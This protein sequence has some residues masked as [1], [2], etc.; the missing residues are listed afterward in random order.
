MLVSPSRP[1]PCRDR[2]ARAV[3]AESS[4]SD[5]RFFPAC[6]WGKGSPS[7]PYL[8]V[9]GLLQCRTVL[10]PVPKCGSRKAGGRLR[11]CSWP[12]CQDWH[13]LFLTPLFPE[14]PCGGGCAPMPPGIS[15]SYWQPHNSGKGVPGGGGQAGSTEGPRPAPPLGPFP[16]SFSGEAKP[17]HPAATAQPHQAEG[18]RAAPQPLR[19]RI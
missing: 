10:A 15:T 12:S 3:E 1:L 5:T 14:A 16:C 13:R 19:P 17:S 11:T 18:W 6:C 8:C 4:A 7:E 9:P 2:P